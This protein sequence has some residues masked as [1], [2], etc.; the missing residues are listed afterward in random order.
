VELQSLG[1]AIFG[2]SG[3]G[4]TSPLDPMAGLRR[5]AFALSR[6]TKR[7][8]ATAQDWRIIRSDV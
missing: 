6:S 4:K 8:R 3:A 2:P 5:P 7:A 1:T